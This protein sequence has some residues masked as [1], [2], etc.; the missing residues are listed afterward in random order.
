MPKDYTGGQSPDFWPALFT[1]STADEEGDI[2]L[3]TVEYDEPDATYEGRRWRTTA[4][5]ERLDDGGCRLAT[6]SICYLTEGAPEK[7][8]AIMATP[9]FVRNILQLEGCTPSRN[10]LRLFAAPQR[11]DDDSFD[12]FA[13]QVADPDRP[14]PL[15]LFSTDARY[16]ATEYAK[17]LSR[18]SMGTANVYILDRKNF[19]LSR[20]VE[21]LLVSRVRIGIPAVCHVNCRRQAHRGLRPRGLCRREPLGMRQPAGPRVSLPRRDRLGGCDRGRRA[22]GGCGDNPR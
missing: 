4:R 15:V 5:V 21:E 16:S 22:C 12:D 9:P 13:T 2:T 6:E 11:L 8:T 19:A 3:W 1:R 14:L 17:Q 20:R 10:G 7:L 18:R